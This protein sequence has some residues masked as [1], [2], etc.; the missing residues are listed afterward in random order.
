MEDL[1]YI[2]QVNPAP[3]TAR[4][5]PSARTVP[6]TPGVTLAKACACHRR[7]EPLESQDFSLPFLLPWKTCNDH[8]T[9]DLSTLGH[10][11]EK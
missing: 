5:M 3:P 9:S 8:A 2:K 11:S 4:P 7:L 1:L 10:V 6:P